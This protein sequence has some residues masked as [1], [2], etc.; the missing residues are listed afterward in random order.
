[1][2]SALMLAMVCTLA[3][4]YPA[5]ADSSA[6]SR[7]EVEGLTV[8]IIKT[9]GPGGPIRSNDYH[10]GETVCFRAIA[11][12]LMANDKGQHN[13]GY[14]Y[15]LLDANDKP[16]ATFSDKNIEHSCILGS[17]RFVPTGLFEVPDDAAGKEY[18][19]VVSIS[20]NLADKKAEAS[21][22]IVVSKQTTPAPISAYF[23]SGG[24]PMS[25]RFVEGDNVFLLF[26][27]ANPKLAKEDRLTASLTLFGTDGLPATKQ[28]LT[29]TLSSDAA[30]ANRGKPISAHF[31]F[32]LDRP[33]KGYARLTVH[34]NDEKEGEYVDI[35]IEVMRAVGK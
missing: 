11:S 22:K 8:K 23:S 17:G 19:L 9:F 28:P 4:D 25:G 16:I 13:V 10:P 2:R 5:V 27:I 35:P 21:S 15:Q 6:K 18:R 20:D 29:F 12:G 14:E 34:I 30:N 33:F 7:K 3:G 26:G 32:N 24:G 1:M 31:K